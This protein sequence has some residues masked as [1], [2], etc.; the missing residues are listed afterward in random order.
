MVES[1]NVLVNAIDDIDSELSED[2]S[3]TYASSI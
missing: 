2:L 3:F 1:L